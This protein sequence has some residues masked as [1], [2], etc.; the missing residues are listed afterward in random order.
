LDIRSE[1]TE[2][3]DDND[4]PISPYDAPQPGEPGWEE[5]VETELESLLREV[6][7]LKKEMVKLGGRV[8]VLMKERDKRRI[9]TRAKP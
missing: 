7:A 4:V 9:P 2:V 3:T 1:E 6:N 5:S 8:N